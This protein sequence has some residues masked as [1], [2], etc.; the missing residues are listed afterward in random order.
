MI[1][2]E[3]KLIIM[4]KKD[5][6]LK[7]C[8]YTLSKLIIEAMSKDKELLKYHNKSG[9]KYYSFDNLYPLAKNGVYKK[10]NLYAF[11][12]RSLNKAFIIKLE[13]EL[14][15]FENANAKVIT[16]DKKI[17]KKRQVEEIISL[18][19]I[20]VTLQQKVDNKVNP[21][22]L[23]GIQDNLVKNL[24]NKYNSLYDTDIKYDEAIHMFTS[25][26][27]SSKPISIAYKGVS[28]LGIKYRFKVSSDSLSQKLAFI[29]EAT[30]IGEKSSSCGAGF[31]HAIYDKEI[32]Q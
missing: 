30:G 4:L 23:G 1:Y 2:F 16:V 24:V 13:K 12:I 8:G 11:R 20:I 3:L 14:Y 15:K 18:T 7:E 10:G 6:A 28:L 27:V 31:C 19:P 5:I 26:K 32:R 29:A 21:N 25:A 9:F 17:H 22:E